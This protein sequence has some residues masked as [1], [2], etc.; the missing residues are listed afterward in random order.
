MNNNILYIST[1]FIGFIILFLV[2]HDIQ[3][4]IDKFYN[5][6]NYGLWIKLYI[7]IVIALIHLTWLISVLLLNQEDNFYF[8]GLPYYLF[9]LYLIYIIDDY[10]E[11]KIPNNKETIA[12]Y[13]IN[14]IL[15]D[16]FIIYLVMII[17]IICIPNKAKRDLVK[18]FKNII[19][20]YIE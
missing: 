5:E 9:L 1:F 10:Y 20:R 18:C 13:K 16:L 7:I 6:I 4:I 11:N 8:Y 12:S 2:K 15:N 19:D 14:I 3:K 17:I